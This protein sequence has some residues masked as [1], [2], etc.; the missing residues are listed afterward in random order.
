MRCATCDL[1]Y[2]RASPTAHQLETV[3]VSRLLCKNMLR[4]S[5]WIELINHGIWPSA[6]A[7]IIFERLYGA[8]R[9]L[10]RTGA[11]RGIVPLVRSHDLV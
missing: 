1:P 2:R 3:P 6:M 5:E 10:H 4:H 7:D 8:R 11:P 9:Y